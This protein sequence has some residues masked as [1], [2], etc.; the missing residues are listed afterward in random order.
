MLAWLRGLGKLGGDALAEGFG[1]GSQALGVDGYSI[2][3]SLVAELVFLVGGFEHYFGNG[4]GGVAVAELN[5][6]I[7]RKYQRRKPG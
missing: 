1:A 3:A 2:G 7:Q 6:Q 5:S 4:L